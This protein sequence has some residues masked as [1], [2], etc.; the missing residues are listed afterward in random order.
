MLKNHQA[1]SSQRPTLTSNEC[2]VDSLHLMVF[3]TLF[4]HNI[5]IWDYSKLETDFSAIRL[6]VYNIDNR[7]SPK[8][9]RCS[10]GAV[11]AWLYKGL[12]YVIDS[13]FRKSL[14]CS[15]GTKACRYTITTHTH[16]P[17][18]R[19]TLHPVSLWISTRC[20]IYAHVCVSLA[21]SGF[22][23]SLAHTHALSEKINV[24]PQHRHSIGLPPQ[25]R[26]IFILSFF[27]FKVEAA[28]K[29]EE[30]P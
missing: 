13:S 16:T 12:S 26:G 15:I 3:Q 8:A 19:R 20:S 17:T 4:N 27:L 24:S 22:V 9:V 30:R 25:S 5:P 29:F 23:F 6:L 11:K 7:V 1:S 21:V 18:D 2:I 10:T 28:R 14:S